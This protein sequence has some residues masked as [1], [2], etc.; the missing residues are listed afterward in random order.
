MITRTNF[1]LTLSAEQMETLQ[2]IKPWLGDHWDN[3]PNDEI[4]NIKNAVRQQ[5]TLTQVKCSYCGLKLNGTSKGEIE[6][7]APKATGFRHPEFTFTLENLT[8]SCHWC[9]TSEK[10]GTKDTIRVKSN[11]YSNCQFN[12]VHPYFD[13]PNDHYEW[14]DNN[15]EILIQVKNNSQ[16]AEFSIDMFK[17]A[18]PEMNE[19]RAMQIR[20]EQLKAN[21][22]LATADEQLIDD[23]IK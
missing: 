13:D 17:L 23:A 10:K 16:K 12:L 5:L 19:H 21:T 9:N 7:I 3:P 2:A 8:F 6:H 4:R 11:S 1:S 14:T 22:P 15:L 18:T 20:F